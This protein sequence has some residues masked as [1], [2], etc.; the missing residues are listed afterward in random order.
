MTRQDLAGEAGV[1]LKTVYNLESGTRWPI[2]TTR[3]AISAALHWEGDALAVILD[4]GT[5]VQ[6]TSLPRPSAAA[7]AG[8]PAVSAGAYRRVTEALKAH[9]GDLAAY[10]HL[11]GELKARRHLI[12]PRY[13]NR[14]LFVAERCKPLGLNY[15]YVYDVEQAGGWGRE[16]LSA[17][18]ILAL[19]DAYAVM[20]ES[21]ADALDGGDLVPADGAPLPRL[22]RGRPGQRGDGLRCRRDRAGPP[23]RE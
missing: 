5:P 21:V 10:R 15:K 19:A 23:V 9:Q 8:H 3:M 2:A 7:P 22:P 4:G 18:K 1:D 13:G 17:G 6:G 14:R 12:D 20:P 11:G 16:G